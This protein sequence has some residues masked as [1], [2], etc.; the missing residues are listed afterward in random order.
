M[1]AQLPAATKRTASHAVI[2]NDADW[3]TLDRRAREVWA[4][5]RTRAAHHLCPDGSSRRLLAITAHPDDEAIAMGGTLARYADAGVAIQ[6]LCVTAGE[7]ATGSHLAPSQLR[8]RRTA[9]LHDAARI[10]G[11]DRV[12]VLNWGDGTLRADD[13]H[14]VSTLG[15]LMGGFQPHVAI[16]FGPEGITGHHD[17]IAVHTWTREARA[18][19]SPA[20]ELLFVGYPDFLAGRAPK[21]VRY[22]PGSHFRVHVDIRPWA[23]RKRAAIAAH[24]TVPYRVPATPDTT[25]TL[26][27][28]E[29]FAPESAA[30]T[31]RSDL[32]SKAHERA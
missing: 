25:L 16:T 32:F 3:A 9:D 21:E 1:A 19:R 4:L 27:E 13:A 29:W 24:R 15:E 23:D 12:T 17:H 14:A 30:A 28:R 5:I 18:V 22:R 7:A 26:F 11:V 2:E 31:R 10:L 6:L 20:T 8:A